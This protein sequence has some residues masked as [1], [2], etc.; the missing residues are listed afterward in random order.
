[1]TEGN[2]SDKD[3]YQTF[4]DGVQ[5]VPNAMKN[6]L[7]DVIFKQ[8]RQIKKKPLSNIAREIVGEAKEE[9]EET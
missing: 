8:K 2:G 9:D 1:M 3:D 6:D 4:L 7:A 5:K